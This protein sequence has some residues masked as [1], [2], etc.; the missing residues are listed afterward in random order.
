MGEG[1]GGA[2]GGES[3]RNLLKFRTSPNNSLQYVLWRGMKEPKL[4]ARG[5]P[6]KD[7]KAEKEEEKKG[8]KKKTVS[9]PR[10][11]PV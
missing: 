8:I 9:Q 5:R 6:H 1:G 4:D 2:W 3:F 7:G 10:L 11:S